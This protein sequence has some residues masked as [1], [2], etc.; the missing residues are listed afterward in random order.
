M[1]TLGTLE[2]VRSRI[3]GRLS[4]RLEPLLV[5]QRLCD[6]RFKQALSTGDIGLCPAAGR[7]QQPMP[8]SLISPAKRELTLA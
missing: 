8:Q 1:H 4:T 2:W 5:G 6:D 7:P 3:M